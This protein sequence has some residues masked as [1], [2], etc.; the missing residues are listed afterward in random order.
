MA[1]IGRLRIHCRH[2]VRRQQLE[3][4]PEAEVAAGSVRVPPPCSCTAWAADDDGCGAVLALS[5][6][7][8]HER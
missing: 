7:R 3:P 2:G 5:E 1:E 4:E 6:R 8:A